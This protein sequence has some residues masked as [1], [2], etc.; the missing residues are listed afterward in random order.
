VTEVIGWTVPA[1]RGPAPSGQFVAEIEGRSMEPRIASGSICLFES[2][3][4]TPLDDRIVL[5]AHASTIDDD[6]DGPYA[7]KRVG[8][9]H[10]RARGGTRITLTSIN[11]EF[12]PIVVDAEDDELPIVA[13][14]VRIL[15]TGPPG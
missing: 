10:R 14:L 11:P 2:P 8:A 5:V 6:L 1:R 13:E 9:T 4:S 12:A 7:L 3:V 15:V